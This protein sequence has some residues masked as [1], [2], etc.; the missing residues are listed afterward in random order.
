MA[1]LQKI[2]K[3]MKKSKEKHGLPYAKWFNAENVLMVFG[4]DYE[5]GVV[6]E[7]A[8]KTAL[9]M[10]IDSD[11]LKM[12]EAMNLYNIITFGIQLAKKKRQ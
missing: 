12:G 7:V 2:L 9:K 1:L 6:E 11:G 10:I 5:L 4:K 8:I 3:E